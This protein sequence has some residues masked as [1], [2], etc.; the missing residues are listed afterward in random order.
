VP[1]G[2][3]SPEPEAIRGEVVSGHTDRPRQPV[4]RFAPEPRWPYWSGC[5]FVATLWVVVCLGVP[6]LFTSR[7]GSILNELYGAWLY[8]APLPLLWLAIVLGRVVDAI[9]RATQP[10]R[11]G[12][13]RHR[14]H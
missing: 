11:G 1:A 6:T 4:D 12:R 8:V 13:P 9:R 5:G 7:P 10:G 2:A 3:D 14:Q